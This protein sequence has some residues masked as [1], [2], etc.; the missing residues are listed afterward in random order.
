MPFTFFGIILIII[1]AILCMILN[2]KKLSWARKT[3]LLNTINHESSK[4]DCNTQTVYSMTSDYC[5]NI[6]RDNGAFDVINGVCVNT[7]VKQAQN[8]CDAEKGVLAYLVGDTQF[9]TTH[10]QCLSVD[11]GIQPSN[12]I[13]K[14]LLCVNGDIEI[15]YLLGYP[16]LNDCKCKDDEFLALIMETSTIRRH[17]ACVKNSMRSLYK[18]N[19]LIFSQLNL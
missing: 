5:N 8:S 14:N 11:P 18:D 12:V 15:N 2:I 3:L 1:F 7:I 17:G 10:T 9:G 16:T 19:N 6:C 13:Q 4:L